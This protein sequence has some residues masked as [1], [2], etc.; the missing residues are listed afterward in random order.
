MKKKEYLAPTI[1]VVKLQQQH[2]LLAGSAV[3][4]NINDNYNADDDYETL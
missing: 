1:T 3:G 2:H 4:T